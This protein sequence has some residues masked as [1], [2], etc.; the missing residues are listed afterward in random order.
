MNR[1][2]LAALLCVGCS[3]PATDYT[4]LYVP[5]LS[6]V[7]GVAEVRGPLVPEPAPEPDGVCRSCD[8]QGWLGDGRPRA[9]CPDCD[10]N[11]DGDNRDPLPASQAQDAPTLYLI[12]DPQDESAVKWA[13]RIRTAPALT[14]ARVATVTPDQ[15]ETDQPQGWFVAREGE[16]VE[17]RKE[18]DLATILEALE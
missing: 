8:G 9:D 10:R 6:V 13:R 7:C 14:Y 16:R 11:G 17:V 2:I 12:A 15:A 18:L 3:P 1:L 4:G 5:G